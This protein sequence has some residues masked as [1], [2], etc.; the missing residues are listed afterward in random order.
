MRI[1][2]EREIKRE[3]PSPKECCTISPCREEAVVDIRL[4]S[5][6]LSTLRLLLCEKH[7]SFVKRIVAP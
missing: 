3:R 7:A 4:V 6:D 5:E 2:T 1:S